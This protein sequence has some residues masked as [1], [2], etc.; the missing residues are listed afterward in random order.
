VV[1]AIWNNGGGGHGKKMTST[2][3][4]HG[5]LNILFATLDEQHW[6]SAN[7]LIKAFEN[8]G[9]NVIRTGPRVGNYD[10]ELLSK[11]DIPVYD[12][13][14]HPE[15]YLY[16]E[17]LAQAGTNID[18][19]FQSEPHFFFVGNKPKDI[20]CAYWCIDC[21]RGPLT[22]IEMA[23]QG[24]FDYVFVCQKYYMPHYTR[25]GLNCYHLPFACDPEIHKIHPEIEEECDIVFAGNTGINMF[26][27]KMKNDFCLIDFETFPDIDYSILR[28]H[29]VEDRYPCYRHEIPD[30]I[31]NASP[32]KRF[33]TWYDIN[34]SREYADRAEYLIRLSKDF[35]TRLYASV[36]GEDYGKVLNKGKIVFNHS[37]RNDVTLR[38]FEAL[39]CGKL[40]ITDEIPYQEELVQDGVHCRTFRKYYAPDNVNFNLDYQRV[41]EIVDYYLTHEEERLRIAQQG[42]DHVYKYHTYEH[43]AS[44]VLDT[45]FGGEM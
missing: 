39:A 43:R 44:F 33:S 29:S 13:R 26:G 25:A 16:D 8:L 15:T 5:K 42:H 12:K 17:I 41:K 19:I 40:L 21:H 18:L 34:A 23:K 1:D 6:I 14:Q 35:N 31:A 45:I 22:H 10:G 7:F 3:L 2:R 32:D 36:L 24:Q 9:H 37:L 20:P 38:V 4:P 30:F 27:D 28:T 11:A